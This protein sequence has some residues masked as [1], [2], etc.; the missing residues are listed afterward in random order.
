MPINAKNIIVKNDDEAQL[1]TY[2]APKPEKPK[3]EPSQSTSTP[4]EPVQKQTDKHDVKKDLFAKKR[5]KFLD[6]MLKS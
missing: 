6:D 3:F 1:Q 2:Q 4:A 5:S